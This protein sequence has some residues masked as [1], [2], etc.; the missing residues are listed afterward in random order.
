MPEHTIVAVYDTNAHAD[1]AMRDLQAAHVPAD[2]IGRHAKSVPT[3]GTAG[4]A[5]GSW[6][7]KPGFWESLFGGTMDHDPMIYDR[8]IEN[9]ST[10]ITVKA[11]DEY[12]DAVNRILE[13]HN[14]VDLDERAALYT[15]PANV[16]GSAM[17]AG[18]PETA[19][20]TTQRDTI[21]LAEETLAVGKRAISGGTT[22]VRRYVVET[23]VQEQVTL[24]EEKVAVERRPVTGRAAGP[25][26][27]SEK[28]IE[29]TA[30]NEEAVVSKSAQVKEE[31]ALR[32]EATEHVETVNDTV[33]RDEV[34]VEQVPSG[35]V[36]TKPTSPVPKI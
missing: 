11:P 8:S 3:S 9:G 13:K 31:I 25:A 5:S 35:A 22:R 24:H 18:M 32:K 1:A 14:P 4:A 21:Q 28:T 27:F 10:V 15:S 34:K 6:A 12:H 29:M 36:P 19:A 26:D 7:P 20:P 17:S 23:P 2:A 30:S 33:R 16:T